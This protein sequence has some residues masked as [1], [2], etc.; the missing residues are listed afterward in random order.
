MTKSLDRGDIPL[1]ERFADFGDPYQKRAHYEEQRNG[2]EHNLDDKAACPAERVV[3]YDQDHKALNDRL[4]YAYCVNCLLRHILVDHYP[5]D[6]YN[7]RVEQY[8]DNG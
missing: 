2:Y 1:H 8:N 4:D 5:F 7:D 6:G 3:K